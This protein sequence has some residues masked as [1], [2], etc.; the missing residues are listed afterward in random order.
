MPM[1]TFEQ[2][3]SEI[4]QSTGRTSAVPTDYCKAI[5][6]ASFRAALDYFTHTTLDRVVYEGKRKIDQLTHSVT[7]WQGKFKIIKEENNALRRKLDKVQRS[8]LP[9]TVERDF[10]ESGGAP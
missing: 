8:T 9:D 6:E 10:E 4:D 1:K 7:F 2:I 3:Q 5:Y